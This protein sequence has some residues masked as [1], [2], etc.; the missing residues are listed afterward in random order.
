[1]A[2]NTSATKPAGEPAKKQPAQAGSTAAKRSTKSAPAPKAAKAAPPAGKTAHAAAKAAP[3]AGKKAPAAEEAVPAEAALAKGH[4]PRKADAPRKVVKAGSAKHE[5]RAA[6][7][8]AP[9]VVTKAPPNK[10]EAGAAKAHR[11]EKAVPPKAEKAPPAQPEA[12]TEEK[13]PITEKV[14]KAPAKP[15]RATHKGH[16]APPPNQTEPAHAHDRSTHTSEKSSP[17]KSGLGLLSSRKRDTPARRTE[18][19]TEERFL[20]NQR[21]AL[22]TERATY[23]EQA[24][25]LRE[26]AESLVEEMEPGDIQFDDESGEGGTVTVDRERDLALSAQALV[27]VDEI[28]HAITKMAH[29]TYGICENCGRLIPKPRLEALPFARLCIDCKSGGLSRR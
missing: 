16:E 23:T 14:A 27:A 19:Y 22:D 7:A 24:R 1:M 29:S 10:P 5:S 8:T 4:A 12:G 20:T 2:T 17:P 13:V 9:V 18:G 3:A 6:K 11:S 28:D 21:Q 15:A 26:E 25:S